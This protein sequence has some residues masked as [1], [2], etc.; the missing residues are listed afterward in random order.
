MSA[1]FST[2]QRAKPNPHPYAIKTSTT[3]LLSSSSSFSTTSGTH[4]YI[5][6]SPSPSP[7]QTGF[8][9]ATRHRYSSLE[10][11]RPLPPPPPAAALLASDDDDTPRRVHRSHSLP[12]EIK[13]PEDPKRWSPAEVS[14]YLTSSLNEATVGGGPT[15]VAHDI[16]T[17]VK[18]KKITGR[19]FLRLNEVDLEESVRVFFL[20]DQKL[21]FYRYGINQLWRTTLVD[22]SHALRR[23]VL[24]GRIWGNPTEHDNKDDD[25]DDNN[26][27]TNSN[28]ITNHK[29]SL[30]T[31]SQSRGR[32]RD[33]VDTLER[34][35][36]ASS[37]EQEE[38]ENWTRRNKDTASKR[39]S[40][41]QHR[42]LEQHQHQPQQQQGRLPQRGSV[43]T[44]FGTS[45]PEPEREIKDEDSTITAH[46]RRNV[47]SN[48]PRLLPF[49]PTGPSQCLLFVFF[50]KC[51][52]T[53]FI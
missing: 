43:S 35:S 38:E 27:S 36:S 52:S 41:H 51:I 29:R 40:H 50:V 6:P 7:T 12:Q 11:P 17:F 20:T 46:T 48:G 34:S 39:D 45:G 23:N 37:S 44:L 15:P 28:Y 5:P 16:A 3:G 10:S 47:N 53:L 25:N 49:P 2:P 21:M 18:D 31:T 1:S 33:M 4:H 13:L 42:S 8:G 14:I 24:R 30:S 22:A 19:R 32:V 9:G 26:L